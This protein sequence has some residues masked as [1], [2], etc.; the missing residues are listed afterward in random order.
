MNLADEATE[1]RLIAMLSETARAKCDANHERAASIL[2]V[3]AAMLL[4]EEDAD[5]DAWASTLN[6]YMVTAKAAIAIH[7]TGG[8]VQ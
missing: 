7:R 5:P 6:E 8:Q 3:A 1:N 4:A 2:L